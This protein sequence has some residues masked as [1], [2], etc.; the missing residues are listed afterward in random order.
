[1][2]FLIVSTIKSR[3]FYD[4]SRKHDLLDLGFKKSRTESRTKPIGVPRK[5]Q[6]TVL[7]K[8]HS[9]HCKRRFA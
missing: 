5:P 8:C 6:L 9:L 4:E 7:Q 3:F 1:M 2:F